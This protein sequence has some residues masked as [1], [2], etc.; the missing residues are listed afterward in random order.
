M[1]SSTQGGCL[2]ISV[3]VCRIVP[4][5]YRESALLQMGS[6]REEGANGL[7]VAEGHV[8]AELEKLHLSENIEG[9]KVLGFST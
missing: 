7:A 9:S 3:T 4:L 2:S 8:E 1:C 5:L 6:W